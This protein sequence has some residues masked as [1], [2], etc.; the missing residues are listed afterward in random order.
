MDVTEQ[1]NSEPDCEWCAATRG[2]RWRAARG[3]DGSK[4]PMVSSA[5]PRGGFQWRAAR[6]RGGSELP[7]LGLAGFRW[8]AV[9]CRGGSELPMLGLAG[10]SDAER[11]AARGELG[12][13]E[14]DLRCR[15]AFDVERRV[16]LQGLPMAIGERPE[17]KGRGG[18]GRGGDGGGGRGKKIGRKVLSQ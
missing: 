4:L 7:M 14:P 6:G 18:E 2:F 11:C 8:R 16:A 1:R 5:R 10:R 3:R 17:G 13:K 9:R 15:A 12:S